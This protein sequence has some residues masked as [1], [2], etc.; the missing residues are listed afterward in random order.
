MTTMRSFLNTLLKTMSFVLPSIAAHAVAVLRHES[1]IAHSSEPYLKI[2]SVFCFVFDLFSFRSV[3]N[4]SD[5]ATLSVLLL[6]ASQ[7]TLWPLI[8]GQTTALA[9]FARMCDN[10]R[11]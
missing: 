9:L 4:V 3:F 11:F 6:A 7:L 2:S 1:H 5:D 8:T 10:N